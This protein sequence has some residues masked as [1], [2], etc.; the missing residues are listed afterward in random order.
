MYF[1]SKIVPDF[2]S[3]EYMFQSSK[4]VTNIAMTA[5]LDFCPKSILDKSK[6]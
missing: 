3:P 1:F 5:F 4:I 2:C 6:F